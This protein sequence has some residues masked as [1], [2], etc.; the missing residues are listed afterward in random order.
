MF[1]EKTIITTLLNATYL[2]MDELVEL[3]YERLAARLI[4]DCERTSLAKISHFSYKHVQEYIIDELSERILSGTDF[5]RITLFW[6]EGWLEEDEGQCRECVTRLLRQYPLQPGELALLK[7]E[8]SQIT[9]FL[10]KEDISK[11]LDALHVPSHI[12]KAPSSS[13]N[14]PWGLGTND[15]PMPLPF[16]LDALDS[17]SASGSGLHYAP[18]ADPYY[19]QQ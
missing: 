9:Q 8:Y 15:I 4:D 7:Q 2:R 12:W 11:L 19:E 5:W 14:I 3:S 16:H 18:T 13:S 1:G 10:T 17:H 6:S